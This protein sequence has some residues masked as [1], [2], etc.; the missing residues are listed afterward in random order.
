MGLRKQ[1][2]TWSQKGTNPQ[3]ENPPPVD[4]VVRLSKFK[5]ALLNVNSKMKMK[6]H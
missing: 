6:V 2:W 3:P 4:K 5:D 1:G